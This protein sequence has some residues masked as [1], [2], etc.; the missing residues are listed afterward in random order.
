MFET[1]IEGLKE[2]R[3]LY[4][5]FKTADQPIKNDPAPVPVVPVLANQQ[6]AVKV[7][8]VNCGACDQIEVLQGDKVNVYCKAYNRVF[9]RDNT[10]C[11]ANDPPEVVKPREPKPPAHAIV[12]DKPVIRLSEEEFERRLEA[13]DKKRILAADADD[14]NTSEKIAYACTVQNHY[15]PKGFIDEIK[16]TDLFDKKAHWDN[17]LSV[18]E[19]TANIKNAWRAEGL[20]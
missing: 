10:K 1:I 18:R 17:T 6:P 19:N 4:V 15:K 14:Q 9:R 2:L 7:K 8:V 16:N 11:P 3:D 5:I 20:A 13:L 12:K